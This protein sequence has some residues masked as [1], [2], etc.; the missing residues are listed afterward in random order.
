MV[1]LSAYSLSRAS[2]ASASI[3]ALSLGLMVSCAPFAA[4]PAEAADNVTLDDFTATSKNGDVMTIKHADFEGANLTKEEIEKILTPDA[5]QEEKTAL[6]QKMKIEKLSIP[7]IDVV[8]KKGGAFHLH[9]IEG[10]DIDSGKIGSLELSGIDGTADEPDGAMTIKAGPLKVEN[11]DATAALS[12]ATQSGASASS[13]I[14]AFSWQNI[15]V[16]APE[17]GGPDKTIHVSIAS[18]DMNNDYDG[19]SLKDGKLTVKGL[20]VQ[21]SKT[22]D[23]AASLGILGYSKLDLGLTS[24]LHYD[25]AA[26]TLA[27]DDISVTGDNMGALGLKANFGDIGPEIFGADKEARMAGLMGGSVSAIELK[28]ANAGLFEKAVAYFAQE[29]KATPEALKKQWAQAAGLM[30]PAVLGGDPA[31]VKLATEAQKFIAAPTSMT[32]ALKPKSGSLKFMDAMALS[33]PATALSKID[34]TATTGK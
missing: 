15:D 33:D 18:I 29:Q 1:R 26:K 23:L 16:V 31:A 14:G 8:I 13:Q 7:A 5:P 10:A 28:F 3:M 21:P 12:A 2:L 9:D 25:A 22:S 24:S 19:A 27:I 30:L 4:S 11:A 17:G 32:I 20:V 6:I 34:V